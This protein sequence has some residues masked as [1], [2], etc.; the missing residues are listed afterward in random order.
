[1][2]SRAGLPLSLP[3]NGIAIADDGQH[4]AS[5]IVLIGVAQAPAWPLVNLTPVKNSPITAR[6]TLISS[7]SGPRMSVTAATVSV[8]IPFG[9]IGLC[10][11]CFLRN[12][13][14]ASFRRR[15]ESR[16]DL[17]PGLRRD[18]AR[19]KPFDISALLEYGEP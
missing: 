4:T 8:R 18:D 2:R 19:C 9:R 14:R 11:G 15:P 16:A 13:Y 17:G 12:S 7:S 1:M 5:G 10:I 6:S 3:G